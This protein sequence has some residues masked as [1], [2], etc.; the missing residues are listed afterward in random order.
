MRVKVDIITRNFYEYFKANTKHD[1][2][3]T[4]Y[5]KLVSAMN[6]ELANIV[7][8][9][10]VIELHNR[11]GKIVILER[12]VKT[13]FN[14][15]T[16]KYKSINWKATNEV[17][18]KKQPTWTIEDWKK[19]P[20]KDRLFVMHNNDHTNGKMYRISWRKA[21]ISNRAHIYIFKP[22]RDFARNLAA[23]LKDPTNKIIYYAEQ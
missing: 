6:T 9:G 22:F 19:L 2:T 18:K 20:V 4:Q 16:P 1:I 12:E 23:I 8:K 14:E 5:N 17:R 10:G 11:N 15:D 13:K 7:L 21:Y 3:Y